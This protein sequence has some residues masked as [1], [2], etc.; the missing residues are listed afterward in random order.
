MTDFVLK[1]F[2]DR[3]GVPT[4]RMAGKAGEAHVEIAATTEKIDPSQ[5]VYQ[6]MF[7][8]GY[9]RVIEF[10]NE[11]HV[12]APRSLTKQQ[13]AF[14]ENKHLT[15]HKR[16]LVN[17]KAVLESRTDRLTAAEIVKKLTA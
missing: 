11:I 3:N 9:V 7:A 14:L 8:L 6:Q 5:D 10:Q 12:D 17:N 1:Y 13:K 16:I 15:E 4:R 2:L